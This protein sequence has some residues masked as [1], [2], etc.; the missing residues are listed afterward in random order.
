MTADFQKFSPFTIL[1]EGAD[2]SLQGGKESR[3]FLPPHIRNSLGTSASSG[4]PRP[5]TNGGPL[6][7]GPYYVPTVEYYSGLAKEHSL[8]SQD[9]ST[10]SSPPSDS[11]PPPGPPGASGA[12][13]QNS[14]FQFSIGKI[15][16]EEGGA[17]AAREQGTSCELPGFYEEV[18]YTEGSAADRG[19]SSPPQLH[20]PDRQDADNPPTDQRPI[21]RSVRPAQ[22]LLMT[23]SGTVS[24]PV[25]L[26]VVCRV[27]MS[28]NDKWHY[29]HNSEVL[30]GSRAMRDRHLRLMGYVILQVS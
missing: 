7:Y 22:P 20:T 29:C 2:E 17:G 12:A 21:R 13:P 9:S 28:V 27:I 18:V 25:R 11:L 3:S 23:S 19:P 26:P 6:D 4:P 10:L 15:L 24:Q 8:E 14:L 16:D 1:E 5:G 30:V